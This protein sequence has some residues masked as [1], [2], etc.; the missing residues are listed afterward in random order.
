MARFDDVLN[1]YAYLFSKSKKIAENSKNLAE[2]MET[3]DQSME[4]M[5]D[6]LDAMMADLEKTLE[7]AY[8]MAGELGVD[9]SGIASEPVHTEQKPPEPICTDIR[10][11]LPED[12]NFQ[13]DF[14]RLVEEAHAAGFTQVH[15]EELLTQEEMA[16]ANAFADRLDEEF[17]AQTK[18]RGKDIQVLTI[19]VAMRVVC[20]FFVQKLQSLNQSESEDIQQIPEA[21]QENGYDTVSVPETTNTQADPATGSIDASQGVDIDGMLNN[22]SNYQGAVEAGQ[23]VASKVSQKFGSGVRVLDHSTILDQNAPFDVQETDLFEKKDIIA[24]NKYL[25]W[26]VGVVNILTDTITTYKM[27]SYTITR[28]EFE[29]AKPCV[30]QEINTLFGLLGTVLRN[31]ATCKDS[32]IAATLQ[33]ALTLGFGKADPAQIRMLFGRAVEL[34]RRTMAVA[35]EGKGILWNLNAKWAECIGG[36]A[37]TALIN[38]IIS[39]IHAI[40]YDES[41]GSLDMYSIRTN[42]IILYAGAVATTVNSMPAIVDQNLAQIDFA[43]ILTT[44][45]SL[46]QSASF[47]IDVKTEFLVS[48][49]KEEL[50]REMEKLDRYFV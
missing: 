16:R 33:E 27:K 13:K 47:W 1:V 44:C 37:M 39:A 18:L 45:I 29:I 28:S 35:E 25:G 49:Y 22:M 7:Q 4:N 3:H 5:D 2:R 48:A 17:A 32:M 10:I 38:T 15:P 41:D 34:E 31:I 42:R 9:I 21:G 19:A 20:Y 50:D 40:L 8:R 46:F 26:I 36:L 14:Q 24:Y 30:N 12:F 23:R 43:G 6:K 11:D